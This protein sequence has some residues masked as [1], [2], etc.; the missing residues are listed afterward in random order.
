MLGKTNAVIGKG[1]GGGATVTAKKFNGVASG[2]IPDD[3][4]IVK[5]FYPNNSL[6]FE[7]DITNGCT[8]YFK[9]K[10]GN[11]VSRF[12]NFYLGLFEGYISNATLALW[13]NEE[14]A[15][16]SV[17]YQT[18]YY[19]KIR[20]ENSMLHASYSTDGVLYSQEVSC[21]IDL[22][23]P[24]QVGNTLGQG[25]YSTRYFSGEIDLN[26]T[27]IE[28]DGKSLWK[29]YSDVKKIDG[30][31]YDYKHS[32]GQVLQVLKGDVE[33]KKEETGDVSVPSVNN[34]GNGG[35]VSVPYE[36]NY[37]NV[38]VVND[39]GRLQIYAN[40]N[41]NNT[42][43]SG[44]D[45]SSGFWFNS[46]PAFGIDTS[47]DYQFKFRL[48]DSNVYAVAQTVALGDFQNELKAPNIEFVRGEDGTNEYLIVSLSNV[49]GITETV[50]DIPQILNQWVTVNVRLNENGRWQIYADKGVVER[51]TR[52][53]AHGTFSMAINYY[54]LFGNNYGRTPA[55][56]VD[57]EGVGFKQNGEWVYRAVKPI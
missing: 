43:L 45:S 41:G 23:A 15:L 22:N 34:G 52:A 6:T 29:P 48:E 31:I 54:L 1:G 18:T 28:K 13:V 37:D 57:L 24:A 32:T 19:I 39:S 33:L 35:D 26:G 36:I 30:Y 38:T 11:D 51:F 55:I 5:D 25:L 10:T 7:A 40:D 21:A 8:M 47:L 16:T 49:T 17:N 12:Q 9:I 53:D 46:A 27:Y 56:S 14:L 4:G 50:L 3:N 2:I 44:F 20:V 42:V